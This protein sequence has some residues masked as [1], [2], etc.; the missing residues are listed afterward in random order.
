M[1]L[2]HDVVVNMANVAVLTKVAGALRISRCEK[3]VVL[4]IFIH[5]IKVMCIFILH[6]IGRV[7]TCPYGNSS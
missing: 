1:H 2:L 5:E 6:S 7:I 3:S 4:K